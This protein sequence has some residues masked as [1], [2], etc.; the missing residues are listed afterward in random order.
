MRTITLEEHFATPAFLDGPGRDLKEQAR[1]LGSRAEHLMRDLCDLGKGRIAQ[2]D[3]A[4]I[5]M[6][7][8][9]LTAPGVEQLE[10]A[11]AAALAHETN[12]VLADAIASYP[13][14]LSGFAALP[15][16]A[17]DQAAEELQRRVSDQ[18]FA[19]AVINGHQRGRYLDD[20]FFWPVLEAAEALDAPIYLHP[21]RPPRPVID[22]SFGGFAPLVTEMLAGPGFGWHIETAVHVLRMVL[23]G[24]FD[25]FP[26]LQVVIGHMGEGLPFFMQRVDVMPVELTR[27]KRPVSAYLRDNLHYTFAGFNFA[28]TFLDLLLE[29]G[30]SRIMFS[31][32]Y[33][34]ASMGKA[35]AFLEQI[36]V[37]AAD[38]ERIAHGNAE[39]LFG[40]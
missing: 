29:I 31:A 6:Q 26:R 14:R 5:D 8:V 9:S 40:L 23:G 25:R 11:D 16:A 32:D 17:P 10:A 4:G 30:V 3:A 19:G 36:P 1:Q 13:T 15:M 28:P 7:V 18:A 2:M 27:L 38:R 35:R 24:V 34:Y 20:K 22:A 39:K 33:P 37:S 12:D 21:T